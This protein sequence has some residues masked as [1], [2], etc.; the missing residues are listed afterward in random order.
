MAARLSFLSN[1]PSFGQFGPKLN[2][3]DTLQ[4]GHGIDVF[5]CIIPVGFDVPN[6]LSH[7]CPGNAWSPCPNAD[8]CEMALILPTSQ[9]GIWNPFDPPG[10]GRGA[11]RWLDSAFAGSCWP[12]PSPPRYSVCTFCMTIPCRPLSGGAA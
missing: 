10:P 9:P 4:T 2:A 3:I 1:I 8:E 5:R 12:N 11:C 7:R 6:L